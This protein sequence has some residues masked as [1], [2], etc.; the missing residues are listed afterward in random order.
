MRITTAF[1]VVCI[2]PASSAE[3]ESI[4]NRRGV[5]GMGE[6]YRARDKKLH[7]PKDDHTMIGRKLAHYTVIERIGPV[8]VGEAFRP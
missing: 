5:G 8:G 3:A 4:L 2:P 6:V 1:L 7:V